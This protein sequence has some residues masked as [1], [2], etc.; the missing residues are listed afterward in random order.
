MRVLCSQSNGLGPRPVMMHEPIE[1]LRHVLVAQVPGL[2]AA[3]HDS[4]IVRLGIANL[5]GV[6]LRF[7]VRL[8][9]APVT[10]N[11]EP[12]RSTRRRRLMPSSRATVRADVA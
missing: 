7:E 10:R 11:E 2:W 3:A 6:L 1:G 9:V 8:S 4:S 12:F 5:Q